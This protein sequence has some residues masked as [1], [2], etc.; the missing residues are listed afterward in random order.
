MPAATASSAS[1][2]A[3]GL[4]WRRLAALLL[5]GGALAGGAERRPAACAEPAPAAVGF[6]WTVRLAADLR[7]AQVDLC[8]TGMRP[9]RLRLPRSDGAPALV[10]EPAAP[11]RF[12]LAP[13]EDGWTLTLAGGRDPSASCVAYRVDLEALE[14]VRAAQ[15]E[16]VGRDRLVA[17]GALLLAPAV[18]PPQAQAQ[19]R[20]VLP[21]GVQ[22]STPW[23]P[24]GAEEAGAAG[25]APPG[26][27]FR[28][29]PHSLL[30]NA[31]LAL[32]RF[33]PFTV[34]AGGVPLHVA[35]LDGSVR[36]TRA[37]IE[38]WL[39]TA[40]ETVATLYGGRL[41]VPRV[42]VL[43]EPVRPGGDPVP[44]G[45]ARQ[46]GGAS[47]HLLLSA[48]ARDDDLP[49]E[50]VGVHEMLHLGLPWIDSADAWF[51]EGFVTYYQEVLRGRAGLLGPAGAWVALDEGFQRGRR[52]ASP[53]TL[54]DDSRDM[55]ASHAFHRVYWGGAAIALQ[56]DLA[57]RQRTQG[58]RSLDDLMRLLASREFTARLGWRGLDLLRGAEER[59][60][61]R[62]L[63]DLA[64][65]LLASEAF[66]DLA[67]A[68]A[69]LGLGPG[70]V[71][72][73]EAPA[74]RALRDAIGAPR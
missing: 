29:D 53:R 24:L 68:Y 39:R 70:G 43:V 3:R 10:P 18:W 34:P 17:P 65:G 36:A 21:P 58:R 28:L 66:P 55:L 14:P 38:R 52:R 67:P 69:A 64:A 51:T 48:G 6:T 61:V 5:L 50:W 27:A 60:G 2:P 26:P 32:G 31:L 35:L 15:C 56:V 25:A 11:G 12:G 13:A 71:P 9:L 73:S 63:A 57:L 59:L 72:V 22:V 46:A 7:S 1:A 23:E 33:E 42:Q 62:G 49:G 37:G 44:F 45:Q 40:A 74:V 41:P 19:V 4:R 54:A 47:L 20:W 16:C 8:F 30:G